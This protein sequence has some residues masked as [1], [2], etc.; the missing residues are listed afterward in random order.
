[1]GGFIL[2]R[3]F[4]IRSEVFEKGPILNIVIA[5]D[6]ILVDLGVPKRYQEIKWVI[7][8]LEVKM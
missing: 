5:S 1:M 4:L 2:N 8:R 3:R 7:D 6:G